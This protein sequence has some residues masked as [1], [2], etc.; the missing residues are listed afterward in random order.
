M[1][2]DPHPAKDI[3]FFLAIYCCITQSLNL[4]N[5]MNY[6]WCWGYP[7]QIRKSSCPHEKQKPKEYTKYFLQ[8]VQYVPWRKIKLNKAMMEKYIND[9]QEGT[10]G[11]K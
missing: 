1:S 7:V 10:L 11:L 6:F 5:I 4:S 2:V 9:V 3:F 8:S